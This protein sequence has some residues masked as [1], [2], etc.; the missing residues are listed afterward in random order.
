MARLMSERGGLQD[1]GC[2]A[3]VYITS[4]SPLGRLCIMHFFPMIIKRTD[5]WGRLALDF[6]RTRVCL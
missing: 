5:K 2:G 3:V 6:M 4:K 1:C